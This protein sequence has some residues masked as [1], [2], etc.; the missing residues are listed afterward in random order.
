MDKYIVEHKKEIYSVYI[1]GSDL[2]YS[3]Q[4]P[5]ILDISIVEVIN[6]ETQVV[7]E[8]DDVLM[9]ALKVLVMEELNKI[10]E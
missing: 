7:V 2:D 6:A 9:Q 10:L 4:P 3:V 1:G 5:M 8:P